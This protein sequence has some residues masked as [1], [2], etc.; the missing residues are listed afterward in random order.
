MKRDKFIRLKTFKK[1]ELNL[2][3]N[4]NE[5]LVLFPLNLEMNPEFLKP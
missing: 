2:Y 1:K 4:S 5:E 3:E